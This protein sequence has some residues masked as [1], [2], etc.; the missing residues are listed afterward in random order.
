MTDHLGC[1]ISPEATAATVERME[2]AGMIV[3]FGAAKSG[4]QGF[5]KAEQSR[6]RTHVFAQDTERK[7]NGSSRPAYRQTRGVCVS[8]GT[9]G[10]I[11][12]AYLYALASG[13]RVGSPVDIATE[14]IYIGSRSII[15]KNQLGNGEGSC[16]CWA[17]EWVARYGVIAR[18]IYGGTDFSE[19]S[20][21]LACA[22]RNVPN[23][24]QN[25]GL[26]HLVAA[27]KVE[28]PDELAD[29]IWAG[30]FGAV[31]RSTYCSSVDRD[32]F[33]IF[34][35]QGGHCT[36]ISGAYLD[37]SGRVQFVE[38]QS[39]GTGR[40]TPSP[41]AETADDDVHLRDGSYPVRAI[42][43]DSAIRTGECWVFSIKLGN[44]FREA[45]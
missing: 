38:Q 11:L 44:E 30:Y 13:G 26:N 16:G 21:D 25:A 9:G 3:S 10:A 36:E 2:K 5:A 39:H 6:G 24:V 4:L 7:V 14:P 23:Q 32:G 20:D 19:P 28:S 33:G 45:A 17:A 22:I 27:H 18:G 29:A 8:R 35:N 15:G 12:D 43:M 37:Q 34:D 42:D 41:I 31:C 40:P 1:F